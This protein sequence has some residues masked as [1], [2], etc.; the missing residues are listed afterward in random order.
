MKIKL[1]CFY[2]N[3][4]WEDTVWSSNI[5]SLTVKC[6]VCY[7]RNIRVEKVDETKNDVY[8]YHYTEENSDDDDKFSID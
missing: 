7:D 3:H 8:G 4:K 2:C 6:P 5:N 1:T